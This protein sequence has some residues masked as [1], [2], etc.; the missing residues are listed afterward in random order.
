MRIILLSLLSTVLLVSSVYAASPEVQA[1][2]DRAAD[3]CAAFNDGQFDKG[4]AVIEVELR[5]QFGSATAEL[6]DKSAYSCSSATSLFCGTGGCMVNLV[7]E[8]E[9]FAWQA[10]GWRLIDWGPD[11]ILLIGRDGS[12]C[13]GA[14]AE[15][16]YEAIV[17]SNG[18]ILTVA[19]SPETR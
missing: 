14:G 7:I 4:D 8:G 10:T 13:G 5:S 9:I 15:V 2:I 19:P 18:R 11:R 12:W 16:C 3:D 1:L 17:W 6:V